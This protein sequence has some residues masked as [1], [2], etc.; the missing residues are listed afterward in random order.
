MYKDICG[1]DVCFNVPG[2]YLCIC[3][4]G[5][6][7]SANKSCEGTNLLRLCVLLLFYL[8]SSDTNECSNENLCDV[9]QRCINTPGSYH[10]ECDIGYANTSEGCVGTCVLVLFQFSVNQY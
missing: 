7:E 1:S 2:D 4:L 10:C 6:Q 5:Y 3:R 8:S 9:N